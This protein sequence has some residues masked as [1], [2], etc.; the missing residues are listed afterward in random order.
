[1]PGRWHLTGCPS[2]ISLQAAATRSA[3]H[4]YFRDEEGRDVLLFIHNIFR[5]VQANSE[6]SALLSEVYAM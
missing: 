3:D 1:M 6:V 5:F 2:L 4:I